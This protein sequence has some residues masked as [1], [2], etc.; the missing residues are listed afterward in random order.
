MSKYNTK[1]IIDYI[2]GNDIDYDIEKLEDDYEFMLLVINYS[3]DI[4]MYEFCSNNVKGNYNFVRFLMNKFNDNIDFICRIIDEF[5]EY[6]RDKLERLEILILVTNILNKDNDNYIRYKSILEGMYLMDK[7]N[8]IAFK[9]QSNIDIVKEVIEYGFWIIIDDYSNSELVMNYY[10][11]NFVYDLIDDYEINIES[12]IHN[13]YKNYK[14]L[15]SYGINNYLLEL[16][17]KY[18]TNLY[19][20]ISTHIEL[21]NDL[22]KEINKIKNRWTTYE[23]RKERNN[24]RDIIYLVHEYYTEH[25]L[26]NYFS[27]A[28]ILYYI[29]HELGIDKKLSRYDHLEDEEYQEIISNLPTDLFDSKI[30]DLNLLTHYNNIKSIITNILYPNNRVKNNNKRKIIEFKPK[31]T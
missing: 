14:E 29:A 28:T 12:D 31:N 10:A 17:F 21:L 30:V 15:E 1:L 20:Y 19:S 2:S 22:K 23:E 5:I 9:K 6:N 16:I 3:N 7:L 25:N 13:K 27:E 24:Y 4:N 26:E 11:I 18:D 8:I